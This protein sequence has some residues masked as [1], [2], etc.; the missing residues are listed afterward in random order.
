MAHNPLG[1]RGHILIGVMNALP[2]LQLA[3]S[4]AYSAVGQRVTLSPGGDVK[5]TG[6]FVMLAVSAAQSRPLKAVTTAL[7]RFVACR[8]FLH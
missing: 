4:T 5:Q 3:S 2:A 1:N 7:T 8:D 6:L